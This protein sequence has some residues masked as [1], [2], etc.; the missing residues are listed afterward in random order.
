MKLLKQIVS[1]LS[2]AVLFS[3]CITE[4]ISMCYGV[5]FHFTYHDHTDPP[6]EGTVFVFNSET[7]LLH[8]RFEFTAQQL[9]EG[10]QSQHYLI[11][12]SYDFVFWSGIEV[13]NPMY[14]Y[15]G[16]EDNLPK[17]ELYISMVQKGNTIE[18]LM[19]DKIMHTMSHQELKGVHVPFFGVET[20]HFDNVA[21]NNKNI[22]ILISEKPTGVDISDIETQL[23]S[24]NWKLSLSNEKSS[25]EASITYHTYE[26]SGTDTTL[27]SK[28]SVIRLTKDFDKTLLI[29]QKSADKVLLNR[30]LTDLILATGKYTEQDLFDLD[31]FLIEVFFQDRIYI[32]VNGWLVIDSDQEIP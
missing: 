14:R 8:T 28:H 16:L 27:M 10:Y 2:L 21:K 29:K 3:G 19:M 12:G 4:D 9:K 5:K 30:N 25:K 20:V 13:D 32:K 22:D 11:E 7:G 1:S 31:T 6:E 26:R 18:D 24:S 17:S 23:R 15:R